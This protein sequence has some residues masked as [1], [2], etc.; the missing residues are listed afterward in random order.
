LRNPARLF[1]ASGFFLLMIYLLA[2]LVWPG[3]RRMSGSPTAPPAPPSSM[4]MRKDALAV[5]N[6]G[7]GRTEGG[8]VTKATTTTISP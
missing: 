7:D 6:G 8:E 4:E 5:I 1:R 3:S 2:R